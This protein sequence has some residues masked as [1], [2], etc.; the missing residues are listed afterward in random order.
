MPGISRFYGIII[1]IFTETGARH[2]LPHLHVAYQGH[3]AVFSI[4]PIDMVEGTLPR[5]QQ[6]LVE[7]WIELYQ[8]D[9]MD[10][11]M[12]ANS[13]APVRR[14]PPLARS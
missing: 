5:R 8:I 1:R 2:H 9:L 14:I 3:N 7:A 13:G 10:N 6:H 12:A 11:W 4:S